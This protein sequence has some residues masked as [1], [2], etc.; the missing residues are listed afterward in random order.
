MFGSG[1]G[2]IYHDPV[3]PLQG[4]LMMKAIVNARN[5]AAPDQADYADIVEL[6]ANTVHAWRVVAD[7]VI[8]S[9]HTQACGSAGEEACKDSEIFITCMFV[10]WT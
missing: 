10:S 9:R 5:E 1:R 3:R 4:L 7:S 2:R 8:D 6:I